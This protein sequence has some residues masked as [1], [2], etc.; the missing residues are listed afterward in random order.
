MGGG[1]GERRLSHL[2]TRFVSTLC[3]AVV[4]CFEGSVVDRRLPPWRS[5]RASHTHSIETLFRSLD[6]LVLYRTIVP[7]GQLHAH[8]RVQGSPQRY[9]CVGVRPVLFMQP[10]RVRSCWFGTLQQHGTV[11]L[12]DIRWTFPFHVKLQ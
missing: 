11:C 7:R 9:S 3:G 5:R 8:A 6:A 4:T 10:A 12:L 1:E 2:K